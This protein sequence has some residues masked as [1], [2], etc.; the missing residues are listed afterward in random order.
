[1]TPN[2]VIP[3]GIQPSSGTWGV[4]LCRAR[5]RASAGLFSL[6]TRRVSK[7]AAFG[8]L[9]G[10]LAGPAV[11]IGLSV[12]LFEPCSMRLS[13]VVPRCSGLRPYL[14]IVAAS[15]F[16]PRLCVQHIGQLAS[17]SAVPRV[18]RLF[19]AVWH[20]VS[21]S[22]A[23]ATFWGTGPASGIGWPSARCEPRSP[24]LC[25]VFS[26]GITLISC[27]PGMAFKLG[28]QKDWDSPGVGPNHLGVTAETFLGGWSRLAVLMR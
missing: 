25:P 6:G 14:G 23:G 12:V 10:D 13:P 15:A 19:P 9:L 18:G 16:L 2:W 21:E 26:G 11:E 20:C 5:F 3:G 27:G 4:W 24:R 28:F 7:S 22:A 8:H 1:M 17:S